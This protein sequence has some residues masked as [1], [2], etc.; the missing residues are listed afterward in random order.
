MFQAD[1]Q[2]FTLQQRFQKGFSLF[3]AGNAFFRHFHTVGDATGQ[4]RSSGLAAG[5]QVPER[6]QFPDL[7]LSDSL[8]DQR[9]PNPVLRSGLHPGPMIPQIILIRAVH[10]QHRRQ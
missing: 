2:F 1:S 10:Q 6:R 9:T 5:L 3:N 4:A 8:F 7:L